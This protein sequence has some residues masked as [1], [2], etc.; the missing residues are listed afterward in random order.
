MVLIAN[1]VI[2]YRVMK[3]DEKIAKLALLCSIR[4]MFAVVNAAEK[5]WT[6]GYQSI[7]K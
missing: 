4:F 6:I 2:R 3:N 7:N 5:Y 1:R